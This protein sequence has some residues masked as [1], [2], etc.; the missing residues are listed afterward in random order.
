MNIAIVIILFIL[1]LFVVISLHELGHFI[2]ARRAGVKVEEF[3]L[4]F[5]PRLFGIKRGETVYSVNAIPAGAFVKS[6]GENDPTVPGS[7]ASKGSWSRLAVY[8]AGPVANIFLAF[9]LLSAF[10]TLPTSVV[11]G[12]GVMVHSIV[13]GSGAEVAGI[14]P[15]DIIL[16]VNRQP[17]YKW[18]D[19]QNMVNSSKEGEEITLLLQR[20]GSQSE[21]SLK[22]EFDPALERRVIGVLLC[23]N[24]VNQVG[25][26]SPADEAGIMPGDTILSI[27]GQVIYNE[28]SMSAA[29][30]SIAEGEGICL[31]LL[32]GQEEIIKEFDS[33][34]H[35]TGIDLGWVDGARIEQ[36]R[37]PVWKA[38]YLGGW[39]ITHMPALIV[40]SIPL[41]R[42]DPGKALVGPIGA[43]QLTVEAVR[44]FGFS[45]MLFMAG[46]ISLGIGLFNFFP[47]PPLDGGGMLVALIEGVR[48]GKRLSPRAMRLAYTMGTT[49][50]ITLMVLITFND[51]LRLIKGGSFGL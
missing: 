33:A 45:N 8:A 37:L 42:E 5:P 7:L 9:I 31:A 38:A 12:N 25:K 32:R 16:E 6:A 26:G 17:V 49:F 27:N 11:V 2:A 14:E 48:R 10:F 18:G 4:G 34:Q 29:L 47:L 40:A 30:A 1:T 35:M 23:W 39:Y 22:P 51:I 41:I 43:G 44:S 36:K 50:L 21:T 19:I 20:D 15:G 46:I 13:E 3:G 28:K 24:I